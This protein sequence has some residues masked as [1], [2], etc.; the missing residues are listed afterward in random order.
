MTMHSSFRS[1]HAMG[2]SPSAATGSPG[3]HCPLMRRG[4]VPQPQ[5]APT[6]QELL[7]QR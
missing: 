3:P 7:G 6:W 5:P 1:P 4:S 2:G